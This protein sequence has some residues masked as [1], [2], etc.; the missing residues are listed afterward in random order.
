MKCIL[1]KGEFD[2]YEFY[3]NKL[4][5]KKTQTCPLPIWPDF[6]SLGLGFCNTLSFPV[7]HKILGS[8]PAW[9]ACPAHPRPAAANCL[10]TARARTLR[11]TMSISGGTPR[12]E[13]R[14]LALLVCFLHNCFISAKS[15]SDTK[16]K[17]LDDKKNKSLRIYTNV[18]L[19]MDVIM[20]SQNVKSR[21]V[22]NQVG[23]L[24]IAQSMK[25]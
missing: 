17:N 9:A 24:K 21:Q 6:L 22:Y 15:I 5:I 13:G 25:G 1:L 14:T 19:K 8:P 23:D 16:N 2:V 20:K 3:L 18:K 7:S 10:L 12:L 11:K 4:S